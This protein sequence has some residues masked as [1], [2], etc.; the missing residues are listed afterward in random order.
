MCT[1][2]SYRRKRITNTNNKSNYRNTKYIPCYPHKSVLKSP[3]IWQDNILLLYQ[4]PL[5]LVRAMCNTEGGNDYISCNIVKRLKPSCWH[6][7]TTT[8]LYYWTDQHL[9]TYIWWAII[10]I[11]NHT[12]WY[13]ITFNYKNGKTSRRSRSNK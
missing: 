1:S 2:N 4:A 7:L 6:K 9:T 5:T 13:W 12:N 10:R 3:G 11:V 8:S